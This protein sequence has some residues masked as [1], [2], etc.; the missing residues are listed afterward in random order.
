MTELKLQV[1][2]EHLPNSSHFSLNI[3]EALH[4]MLALSFAILQGIRTWIARKTYI[5][6]YGVL[7]QVWY[8]LVP[9]PDICLLPYF[10]ERLF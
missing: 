2:K 7:G 6:P 10:Y 9:I 3:R 5:S 1:E 4:W 8:L